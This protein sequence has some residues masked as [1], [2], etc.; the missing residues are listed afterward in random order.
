MSRELSLDTH[1]VLRMCVS[2]WHLVLWHVSLSLIFLT[3]WCSQWHQDLIRVVKVLGI[4]TGSFVNQ[5]LVP[6][7]FCNTY[8]KKK[9]LMRTGLIYFLALGNVCCERQKHLPTRTLKHKWV[10]YE[11][12]DKTRTSKH[13]ILL[14]KLEVLLFLTRRHYVSLSFF[15]NSSSRTEVQKIISTCDYLYVLWVR[16][17]GG[18]GEGVRHISQHP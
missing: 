2:V 4:F 10:T 7:G 13:L 11:R 16:L 15:P 8:P 5:V 9:T 3:F 12:G 6:Q 1:N 14:T 17:G 18:A